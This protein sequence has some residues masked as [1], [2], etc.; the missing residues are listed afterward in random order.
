MVK[1]NC[2][3]MFK[4]NNNYTKIYSSIIMAIYYIGVANLYGLIIDFWVVLGCYDRQ[5][6]VVNNKIY[7]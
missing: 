7:I 3:T 4:L 1:I 5:K 2:S 6:K